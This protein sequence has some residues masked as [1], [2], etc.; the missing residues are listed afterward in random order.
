MAAVAIWL[1]AQ[2]YAS[3]WYRKSDAWKINMIGYIQIVSYAMSWLYIYIYT[4]IYIYNIYIPINIYMYIHIAHRWSPTPT[5]SHKGG[6][7]WSLPIPPY[8]P[9]YTYVHPHE[10]SPSATHSRNPGGSAPTN[11]HGSAADHA[12]HK[13]FHLGLDL[14]HLSAV[15]GFSPGHWSICRFSRKRWQRRFKQR[16]TWDLSPHHFRLL[17]ARMGD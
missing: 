10:K 9:I 8:T 15:H 1:L 17:L 12:L 16:H 3:L 4:Y 14:C 11:V 2:G 7:G 5:P 6:R 13:V